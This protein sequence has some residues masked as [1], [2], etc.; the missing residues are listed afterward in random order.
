MVRPKP[1]GVTL[2]LLRCNK[3]VI[4]K[5]FDQSFPTKNRNQY[6]KNLLASMANNNL[7]SLTSQE[8]IKLND[9]DNSFL[10]LF[11]IFVYLLFK[12]F[13][14]SGLELPGFL[15]N[16][17]KTIRNKSIPLEWR[18]YIAISPKP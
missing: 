6:S 12:K 15:P 14:V 18:I 8:P 11:A 3:K 1:K 13:I 7:L 9:F 2:C 4:N 5:Q 10:Y 16:C 17:F